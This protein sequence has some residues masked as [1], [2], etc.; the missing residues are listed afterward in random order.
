MFMR[1]VAGAR[2]DGDTLL[3]TDG[4]LISLPAGSKAMTTKALF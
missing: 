3:G 2:G 4:L 1:G